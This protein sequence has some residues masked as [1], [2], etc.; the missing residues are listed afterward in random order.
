MWKKSV[1]KHSPLQKHIVIY[2]HVLHVIRFCSWG[3]HEVKCASK[4][5]ATN[6]TCL[7]NNKMGPIV[8]VL[9]T[10]PSVHTTQVSTHTYIHKTQVSNHSYIHTTQVSTHSYIHNTGIHSLIHTHNSGIQ[11]LIHTQNKHFF[12]YNYTH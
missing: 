9:Y 2:V 7:T 11:S 4:C 12:K 1:V 10:H 6:R 5:L 3:G 8:Y